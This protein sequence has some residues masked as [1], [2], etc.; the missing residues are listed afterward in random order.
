MTPYRL[1]V[2]PYELGRLRDGVGN[3][4]ERLLTAGVEAVLAEV[5]RSGPAGGR[6]A[7]SR[8]QPDRP[9]RGRRL[10]RSDPAGRRAGAKR[11]GRRRV[12]RRPL[13]KLL[14]RGRRRRRARRA[15][16]RR[17]LARR[18][19]RLQHPGHVDRGLL[20]RHGAGRAHGRRVAGDARDR[21]RR[22]AGARRAPVVLAGARTSTRPR[23]CGSRRRPSRTCRRRS[24]TGSPRRW[25]AIAPA[26]SGV[27]LHVD[28]DVLDTDVARVNIYGAA[29]GPSGAELAHL[30]GTVCRDVTG[31]CALADRVRPRLRPGGPR[32]ADRARP[33]AGR[34]RVAFADVLTRRAARRLAGRSV[35]QLG[36]VVISR[37]RLPPPFA[38]RARP[39]TAAAT[40]AAWAGTSSSPR[41]A[42]CWREAGRRG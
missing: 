3:G 12:P 16:A 31:A 20:R 27:Y 35:V 9:R 14:C 25:S 21:A 33:A 42:S 5:G 32:A 26:P 10:L 22:P 1:I 23:W 6:R 36:C 37:P 39:G 41:A 18:P 40:E 8:V 38:G 30:V 34:R 13:G 15:G 2:V 19:C 4:P 11:G 7:R 17:R 24:W 29:G 28:L